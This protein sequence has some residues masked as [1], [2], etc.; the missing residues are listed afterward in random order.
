MAL[1]SNQRVGI[2]I[3]EML[4]KFRNDGIMDFK[5]NAGYPVPRIFIMTSETF[6]CNVI[7]SDKSTRGG[8]NIILLKIG[9]FRKT[10]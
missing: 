7:V 2:H 1:V 3:L 5:K 6:V 10:A 4:L 9:G 8:N